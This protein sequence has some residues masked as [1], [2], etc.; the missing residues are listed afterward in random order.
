VVVR[1][2]PAQDER[3]SRCN[4]LLI[5]LEDKFLR[6]LEAKGTEL[7]TPLFLAAHM[8]TVAHKD[9]PE[10]VILIEG[11]VIR[12][13][14]NS[15]LGGDD[16]IGIAIVLENLYSLFE[17]SASHS[18]SSLH[19]F[20]IIFTVAKEKGAIGARSFDASLLRAQQGFILDGET[21]VATAILLAPT[22]YI[23]TIS[24]TGKKAH[25]GLE[26]EKGINAVQQLCGIAT[27]LPSG[28]LDA[29]STSNI[30]TI[31]GGEAVN[32]V[33]DTAELHGELRSLDAL[34]FQ[35]H[36]S[37]IDQKVAPASCSV[38]YYCPQRSK[39]AWTKINTLKR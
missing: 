24:S 18:I 3:Y 7:R 26:P 6:S 8:D 27:M 11:D 1:E 32:V 25:A 20:E 36:K 4:S 5:T 35:R 13:D 15:I 19:P 39:W 33:P 29:D 9:D 17:E 21:S 14:G 38:H 23:Y 34:S 16:K 28:R 31:K 30:G 12:T 22:K 10:P 2:I 37:Y